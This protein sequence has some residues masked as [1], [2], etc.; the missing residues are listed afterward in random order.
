MP[1]EGI[2][3]LT[4]FENG[5]FGVIYFID[6][7]H[8]EFNS[9]ESKNTPIEV[10][11]EISQQRKQR[12]TIV[13]TCQVFERMAKPFREQ[14]KYIVICKKFFNCLQFNRLVDGES[15]HEENGKLKFDKSKLFFWFHTPDLYNSYDTYEK[16]KRYRNEWKGVGPQDIYGRD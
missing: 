7:I 5:E 4:R 8:L 2:E 6:E 1:Y 14:V 16:I 12:K 9:L 10:M 13:G 3:S 11:V 15:A